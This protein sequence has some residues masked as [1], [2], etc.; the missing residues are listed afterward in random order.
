M[1]ESPATHTIPR[2]KNRES[3]SPIWPSRDNRLKSAILLSPLRLS[4][5]FRYHQ[6]DKAPDQ[7]G[8]C[9]SP[10]IA[11]NNFAC[12]ADSLAER[13]GLIRSLPLT[14]PCGA[15]AASSPRQLYCFAIHLADPS[16]AA[17]ERA[18]AAVAMDGR[19]RQ[20]KGSRISNPFRHNQT[21]P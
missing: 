12:K 9:A 5:G 21:G 2:S 4:S 18:N 19:E 20:P 6:N 16:R 3:H 10:R 13:E 15:P 17:Q 7:P 8:L 14:H 1:H 11:A